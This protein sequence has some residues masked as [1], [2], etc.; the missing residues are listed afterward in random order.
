MGNPLLSSKQSSVVNKTLF[1]VKEIKNI[2]FSLNQRVHG[3]DAISCLR[4]SSITRTES[5][6]PCTL[7]GELGTWTTCTLP[8]PRQPETV[9]GFILNR[10]SSNAPPPPHPV[11]L[12]K[13]NASSCLENSCQNTSSEIQ[14]DGR[15]QASKHLSFKS[16]GPRDLRLTPWAL[17]PYRVDA[18]QQNHP[19]QIRGI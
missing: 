6:K 15:R 17:S 18:K 5:R 19:C 4:Y 14:P 11:I 10:K 16:Q 8:S 3:S 12:I 9:E 13:S 1:L 2:Q 7:D